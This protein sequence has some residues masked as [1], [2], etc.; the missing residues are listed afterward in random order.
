MKQ[1]D[2]AIAF[3]AFSHEKFAARVPVRV[4]PENWDFSPDV[5]RRMQSAFTQD[6]RGHRGRRCFTVHSDDEN[7]ALRRHD[8][9]Q[10]F[11]ATRS[12]LPAFL[13]A[14]QN[15]V[16]LFD[17]GRINDQLCIARVGGAMLL[18]KLQAEPLEP[19]SFERIQ[20]VR[21]ADIV[22]ELKEK[23]GDSA[24]AAAGH[25][26]EMDGVPFLR[27]EFCKIDI[28]RH[29]CVYFSMVAAT[30]L[31]ASRGASR[32]ALSDIRR[33]CSGRSIITLIF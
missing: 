5:V 2:R 20:F 16:V 9:S 1:G 23:A 26:D 15:R 27:Q 33:S 25:A 31:A 29:D 19:I 32:A 18:I 12:F 13:S 6:V 22:A 21:A 3:V 4:G 24:H 8:R 11:R 10:C 14:L 28:L 17:R 7:P 30:R